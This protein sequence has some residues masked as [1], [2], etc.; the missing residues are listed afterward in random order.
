MSYEP[1]KKYLKPYNIP[2]I[3]VLLVVHQWLRRLCQQQLFLLLLPLEHL[4]SENPV[5]ET[6]DLVLFFVREA[7]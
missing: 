2:L 4:F 7:T 3:I 6:V 5:T 1:L